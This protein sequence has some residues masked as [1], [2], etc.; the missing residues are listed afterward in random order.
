MKKEQQTTNDQAIPT[1]LLI[2]SANSFNAELSPK[3]DKGEQFVITQYRWR[4]AVSEK[5]P[6]RDIVYPP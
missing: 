6:T 3:I 5:A 2:R 1:V 4:V